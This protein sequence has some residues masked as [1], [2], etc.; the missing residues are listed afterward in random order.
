[1]PSPGEAGE[2]QVLHRTVEYN[3]A[4]V[5]PGRWRWIILAGA[6]AFGEPRHL[7]REAAVAACIEEINN[8]IERSRQRAARA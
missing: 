8:G 4:E 5:Q 1:M 3:V 2:F 6:G 7:T